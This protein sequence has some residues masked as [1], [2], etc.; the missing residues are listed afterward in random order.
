MRVCV[1]SDSLV[2]APSP[3]QSL[4]QTQLKA[5]ERTGRYIVK[6]WSTVPCVLL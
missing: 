1:L 2:T 5:L 3:F 4:A 6:K